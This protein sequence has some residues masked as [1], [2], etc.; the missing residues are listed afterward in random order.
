MIE[1]SRSS[2]YYAPHPRTGALSEDVVVQQ[3]QQIQKRFPRYGYRR[4][5]AMFQRQ[6]LVINAK[7]MRRI[8]KTH[9]LSPTPFS[10]ARIKTTDSSHGHPGFP[11]LLKGRLVD[12][13]DQVWVTDITYLRVGSSFA[14]L[15]MILDV[16]SRKIIG[17]A[18]G[19][20]LHAS[21]C[22][23][24]LEE[25]LLTRMPRPR[26]IHHSDHGVQYTS[27][28]YLQRL[29]KAGF[30]LSMANKGCSWENG[31]AESFFKTLKHEEVLWQEYETMQQAVDS[32]S[33]FIE[34]VYNRERLHSRL[35]YC[36]PEEFEQKL[37]QEIFFINRPVIK[38]R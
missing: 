5:V 23:A 34:Q 31:Y 24:A 30:L 19:P 11:N 28:A 21:L 35:G 16:Y 32:V 7:R 33:S 22:Q 38:L 36:S 9:G 20:S 26:C 4:L 37:K 8:L 3:I 13:I 29:E 15:A 10:R 17:W 6:G 18:L 1:L 2:F 25:A 27:G 12:F 14:Y